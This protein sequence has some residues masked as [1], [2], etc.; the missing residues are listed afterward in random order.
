M[1][2]EF[3]AVLDRLNAATDLLRRSGGEVPIEVEQVV[4]ALDLDLHAD[5]PR[6][7]DVDP[8]LSTALFAAALRSMKAL[9]HDNAQTRYRD[10]RVALEQLRHALRDII[11]TV[12]FGDDEPVTEVAV[13]LAGL[14][15]VP[16]SEL[17]GVLGVSTR[18]WQRWLS[19]EAEPTGDDASRL[20]IVGQIANQL[21]HAF[22]A[23]GV[24]RWFEREHPHLGLAPQALLSD[25]LRYPELVA[26]ARGSRTTVG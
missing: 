9:R 14:V 21:R 8:Y 2:T 23:P 12:S 20:R 10:L 26:L 7:L 5:A 25:P 3:P 24:V 6:G 16:Q 19:G 17:A 13:R 18:Q 22:T 11:D 1:V 15:Q 4:E